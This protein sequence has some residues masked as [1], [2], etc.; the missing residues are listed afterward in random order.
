MR[1]RI[2]SGIA[3]VAVCTGLVLGSA[4]AAT[5]GGPPPLPDQAPP[6]GG[7]VDDLLDAIHDVINSP[8]VDCW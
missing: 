3:A 1:T 4:G 5:A 7:P 6:A 8:C 2:I